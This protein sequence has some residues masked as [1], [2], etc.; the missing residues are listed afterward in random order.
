[1][2]RDQKASACAKPILKKKKKK[3]KKKRKKKRKRNRKRYIW[4]ECA[5]L[6][7]MFAA[8]WRADG[9]MFAEYARRCEARR[10]WRICEFQMRARGGA[11]AVI[12]WRAAMD[13]SANMRISNGTS[14]DGASRCADSTSA[15]G[16]SSVAESSPSVPFP[17]SLSISPSCSSCSSCK[18]MYVQ[19][20]VLN[21]HVFSF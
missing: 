3:K 13:K 21:R 10:V 1:L 7:V 6:R 14:S 17:S 18:S 16:A 11:D 12:G 5:G 4:R 20:W 15:C 19:N 9:E 8:E 2:R